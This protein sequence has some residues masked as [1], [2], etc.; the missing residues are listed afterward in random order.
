MDIFSKLETFAYRNIV[1]PLQG[2]ATFDFVE[3]DSELTDKFIKYLDTTKKKY[4]FIFL[5]SGAIDSVNIA[6]VIEDKDPVIIG[7]ENF[8]S[9]NAASFYLRLTDKEKQIYFIRN[10]DFLNADAE[11]TSFGDMYT[12]TYLS[13]PLLISAYTYDATQIILKSYEEFGEITLTSIRKLNYKGI[14]GVKINQGQFNNSAKYIILKS[15]NIGYEKS[16]E[17]L[18]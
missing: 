9:S 5:L 10:L 2:K 3:N 16:Y 4:K 15:T 12:E 13:K 11:L 6:N 1:V 17:A 8:G 7:T 18:S 14:T